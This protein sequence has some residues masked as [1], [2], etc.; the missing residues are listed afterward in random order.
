MKKVLYLTENFDFAENSGAT[1]KTANT[2][3]TLAKKFSV[4]VL[5][6]NSGP[7]KKTTKQKNINLESIQDK[8]IEIPVKKR[9]G[10]LF[11]NYLQLNPYYFFQYEND[12]FKKRVAEIIN[13]WQPT[14]VHIDH[15]TMAQYLP[16]EKR[17]LWVYEE[18]NIEYRLRYQMAKFSRKIGYHW[19]IWLIEAGL[20]F[21]KEKLLLKRFD[22]IFAI[23]DRDKKL[24]KKIAPQTRIT[25]QPLVFKINQ[26]KNKAVRKKSFIL[27]FIG[28]LGWLPN[29][30]GISWFIRQVWPTLKN[31]IPEIK[32]MVVGKESENLPQAF[33]ADKNIKVLGFQP[34]L[35]K[36]WQQAHVF[37]APIRMAEGMR[38]KLFSAAR[39]NLP[40]VTSSPALRGSALKHQ[41][42]VLVADNAM[43]F[44][45]QIKTLYQSPQLAKNLTTQ[46]LTLIKKN[47]SEKENQ[48]FLAAYTKITTE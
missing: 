1:I 21:R 26:Q 15:L 25:T 48:R 45:Q 27:L 43:D 34:T 23:A 47:H 41:K 19:L 33:L 3:K 2:I 10:Q 16:E 36:I 17:R 39:N 22:H 13:T 12:R 11:S 18:H 14:V 35:A 40:I 29:L 44:V 20:I 31:E 4:H 38:V 5:S 37:I 6:L 46:A 30:D 8:T 28:N 42:S 9:L 7:V 24:L 32:L